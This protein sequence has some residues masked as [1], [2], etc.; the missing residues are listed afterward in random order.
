MKQTSKPVVKVPAKPI[1]REFKT[2]DYKEFKRT[3]LVMSISP[4]DVARIIELLRDQ[5]T[6]LTSDFDYRDLQD[7]LSSSLVSHLAVWG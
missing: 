4:R 1:K 7:R 5:P 2:M 6:T 3:S